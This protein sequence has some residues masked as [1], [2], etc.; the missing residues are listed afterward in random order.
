[1]KTSVPKAVETCIGLQ[2]AVIR[3]CICEKV[4]LRGQ[5]RRGQGAKQGGRGRKRVGQLGTGH[6]R[7]GRERGRAPSSFGIGPPRC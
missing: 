2:S 1:M 3:R 7:R 6:R 4:L 5:G